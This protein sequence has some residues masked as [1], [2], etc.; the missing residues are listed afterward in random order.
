MADYKTEQRLYG[1]GYNYVC[2]IDDSA[3]GNFAGSVFMSAVIFPHSLDFQ[4]L[5]P[6]L[7]DSK[8]KSEDQRNILYQQIKQH[9]LAYSTG[10]ASVPEIDKLNIYWAKFLAARRAIEALSIA[11][12]YVLIDGGTE[13]PGI[14]IP[15]SAVVK[16]DQK[17]YSIAAASILAKVDADVHICKL[18]QLVHPDHEWA[19]NKAYYSANLIAALRKHG[20]N[21]WHRQKYVAKF[22]KETK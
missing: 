15:Q 19:S 13:I 14:D 18:A 11:P 12:D 16:G 4:N 8:Q 10:T 3:V 6:G 21:E 20:K 7:N 1:L 17:S 2:G 5:I 9:A 22:L